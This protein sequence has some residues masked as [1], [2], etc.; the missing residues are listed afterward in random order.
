MLGAAACGAG[1]PGPGV[2]GAKVRFAKGATISFPDFDLT[3]TGR[4]HEATKV[5]PHGF[6][7]EDFKISRGA[8][9]VTAS[10]SSGTGLIGP[11]SFE[12]A[13]Q[14]FTLELKHANRFK[15]WL[16]EDELVI[17]KK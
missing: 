10:W 13:G 2:Y 8:K 5:Y 4:R 7:Y 3:Y 9:S 6:D 11:R 17:E 1:A 16:K 14:Q 15:G 12:F